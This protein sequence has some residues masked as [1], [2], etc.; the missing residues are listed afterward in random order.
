MTSH[1]NSYYTTGYRYY[2]CNKRN[3]NRPIRTGDTACQ[4]LRDVITLGLC[5]DV[6]V[7][8]PVT[9]S[10]VNIFYFDC[11]HT[12]HFTRSVT[13]QTYGNRA[14]RSTRNARWLLNYLFSW[15]VAF[16]H[17][18]IASQVVAILKL[19]HCFFCIWKL[20]YSSTIPCRIFF[21]I[22]KLYASSVTFFRKKNI[23]F[24]SIFFENE[25]DISKINHNV[26]WRYK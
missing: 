23:Y 9:I 16:F 15:K 10:F 14:Y 1:S 17:L 5:Y 7:L 11:G 19:E 12:R 6:I 13:I 3:Q 2:I 21:L 4:R 18:W 25:S 8:P 20:I 26:L 24:S 22:R